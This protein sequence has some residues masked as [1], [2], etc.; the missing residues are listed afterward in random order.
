MALQRGNE[1]IE[2]GARAL[3]ITI[4]QFLSQSMSLKRI[5]LIGRFTTDTNEAWSTCSGGEDVFACLPRQDGCLLS[6]IEHFIIHGGLC[7][8]TLRKSERLYDVDMDA[9]HNEGP[10][11]PKHSWA[12]EED[13]GSVV[14]RGTLLSVDS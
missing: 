6:Q 13:E 4:I 10:W 7:P 1:T 3:W 11:I 8:F 14:T 2:G 12:W 5:K 9:S